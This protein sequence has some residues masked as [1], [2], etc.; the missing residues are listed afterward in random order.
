MLFNFCSRVILRMPFEAGL[1]ELI[2]I[3]TSL[4]FKMTLL[5]SG[6]LLLPSA[7]A[8]IHAHVRLACVKLHIVLDTW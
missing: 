4:Q 8:S 7:R 3:E 1:R 2:E 5:D 6:E